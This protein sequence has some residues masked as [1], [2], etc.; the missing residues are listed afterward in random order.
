MSNAAQHL[1]ALAIGAHPDDIEFM[2]AG[3][4]LRLKQAGAGIHM[5]NLANGSCGTVQH[6]REEIIALRRAEVEASAREAGATVHPALADDLA[7]FYEAGLLARVAAVMRTVRPQILL[8]PSPQDY[9]EDHSN[10]CRLAVTAAFARGMR[11]YATDPPVAPWEG[12]VV[13]YHALPHGLCDGLRHLVRPEYYVDV[14]PVLEQK[15]AMLGKHET[16]KA[17]LD[18]SQGMGSYLAQMEDFCRQV[19]TL[20][21]GRYT[22]AEGWRRHSHWG[23][24]SAESDPLR[25]VLGKDCWLDPMYY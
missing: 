8:I 2:M 15:Q 7:I 16:Q 12:E 22:Y 9:M 13:L 11:N 10:T 25:E 24:A 18:A 4:L 19:G 6:S 20:S 1:V 3:T 21:G 14:G 17:W 5:W 23:F